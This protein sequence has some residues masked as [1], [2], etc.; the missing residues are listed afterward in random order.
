MSRPYVSLAWALTLPV[1]FAQVLFIGC[2]MVLVKVTPR[3]FTSVWSG[4]SRVS[5]VVLHPPTANVFDFFAFRLAPVAF[6]WHCMSV[7]MTGKSVGVMKIVTS[8]AYANTTVF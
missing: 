4:M 6:S 8:S 3:I 5:V 1:T 2:S 7:R